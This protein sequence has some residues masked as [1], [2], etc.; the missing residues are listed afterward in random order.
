M[1]RNMLSNL[2]TRNRLHDF[3]RD[4]A[5]NIRIFDEI[6]GYNGIKRTFVRSLDSKEPVHILLVGPPGQAKTLFL[7]Y[8]RHSEIEKHSLLSVVTSANQV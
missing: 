3:R 7:K 4:I 2:L 5:Q 1:I 8:S 6:V